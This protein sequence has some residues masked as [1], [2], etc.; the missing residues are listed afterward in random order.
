[1]IVDFLVCFADGRW[2]LHDVKG[3]NKTKRKW[4][5]KTST[6][7][8]KKKLLKHEYGLDVREV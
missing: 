8:L 6:Y 2:E 3:W 5:T 1:M 7:N 4:V